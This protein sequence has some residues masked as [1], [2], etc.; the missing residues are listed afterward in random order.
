MIFKDRPAILDIL[1]YLAFDIYSYFSALTDPNIDYGFAR[2][3]KLVPRHPGDPEKLPKEV[4]LKRAADLAEAIY[5]MPHRRM[6]G[7]DS[8]SSNYSHLTGGHEVN[9]YSEAVD[10]YNRAHQVTI[11]FLDENRIT[12][13][14]F[15]KEKFSLL[16]FFAFTQEIG[17]ENYYLMF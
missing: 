17:S 14:N 10:D 4:V 2:L 6:G 3:G 7:L 16:I 15:W 12:V 8:Y 13:E 1:I 5:A 11:Q 9:S